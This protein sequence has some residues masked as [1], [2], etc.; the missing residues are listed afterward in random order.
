MSSGQWDAGMDVS[1]AAVGN[2]AG[3]AADAAAAPAAADVLVGDGN[4]SSFAS[5]LKATTDSENDYCAVDY[6]EDDD[7][8]E[9][10]SRVRLSLPTTPAGDV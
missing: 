5:I 3:K 8:V 4:L 9:D 7:E 10:P 2:G 6:L 1:V